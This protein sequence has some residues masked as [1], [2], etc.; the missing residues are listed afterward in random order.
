MRGSWKIGSLAGV[1]IYLHW[2]FLLLLG[3]VL[4]SPLAAGQGLGVATLSVVLIISL[5][6]CVVLHELGHVLGLEH[7]TTS[8]ADYDIMNT[9]LSTSTRLLPQSSLTS[10][11]P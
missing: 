11:W 1:G 5:F 4:F 8:A 9:T 6:G 2:T 3:W 7:I 10:N